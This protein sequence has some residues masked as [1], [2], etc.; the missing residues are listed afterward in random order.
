MKFLFYVMNHPELLVSVESL[1]SAIIQNSST[2]FQI[3]LS[4]IST[5]SR[6]LLNFWF[7]F[8]L[9]SSLNHFLVIFDILNFPQRFLTKYKIL[10]WILGAFL[11]FVWVECECKVLV[12]ESSPRDKIGDNY[13][14]LA[15][16]IITS[17]E[18]FSISLVKLVSLCSF[19]SLPVTF[20]V[21]FLYNFVCAKISSGMHN[22]R[23]NTVTFFRPSLFRKIDLTCF[24]SFFFKI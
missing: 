18:S 8:K 11:A 12:N 24:W 23:K 9:K 6:H 10:F 5:D 13:G 14:I 17:W 3:K 21:L 19:L 2:K 7:C 20:E 1:L 22:L 16:T 15:L 4:W